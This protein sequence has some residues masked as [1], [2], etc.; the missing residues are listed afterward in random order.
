MCIEGARDA[1][2]PTGC[3]IDAWLIK[4]RIEL[5]VNSVPLING[6][7]YA[8]LATEQTAG[9]HTHTPTSRPNVSSHIF[10]RRAKLIMNN[11]PHIHTIKSRKRATQNHNKLADVTP[12]QAQQKKNDTGC[13]S[14]SLS[15]SLPVSVCVRS[16]LSMR[17]MS[18]CW[19]RCH[20]RRRRQRRL[21]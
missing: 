2:S 13:L 20:L 9:P 17:V 8:R 15:P 6:P 1:D 4:L 11:V 18:I 14:V 7:H 3:P 5:A 16:V 19:C 21:S 10:K 12:S